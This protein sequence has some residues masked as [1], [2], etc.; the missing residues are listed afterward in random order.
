MKAS[1]KQTKKKKNKGFN[2]LSNADIIMKLKAKNRHKKEWRST[3]PDEVQLRLS[4]I[5]IHAYPLVPTRIQQMEEVAQSDCQVQSNKHTEG[6]EI[7]VCQSHQLTILL[8]Q[9]FTDSSKMLNLPLNK[10]KQI[11][12]RQDTRSAS[13]QE[14][15]HSIEIN[16]FINVRSKRTSWIQQSVP[17]LGLVL[18]E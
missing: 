3:I 17:V 4:E 5:W 2:N 12:P 7:W 14:E 9:P 8:V 10:V 13:S 15:V 11:S 16:M 18:M 6:S 1:F